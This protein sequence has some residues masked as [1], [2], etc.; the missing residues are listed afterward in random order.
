MD[1]LDHTIQKIEEMKSYP[2]LCAAG[3]EFQPD[4]T[5]DVP[6]QRVRSWCEFLDIID[7]ES[8]VLILN[9]TI[10]NALFP[11]IERSRKIGRHAWK[12][13]NYDPWIGSLKSLPAQII[14]P[15]QLNDRIP[16]EARDEGKVQLYW[17]IK[18][19]VIYAQFQPYITPIPSFEFTDLVLRR[20]RLA[21][22]GDPDD[23]V[24]VL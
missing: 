23:G 10:K 13:K 24:L 16:P 21:C 14:P 18:M 1:T 17:L 5:W 3:R 8:R 22:G 9:A 19:V 20:G 7:Q 11:E 4:E 12:T 15:D 2:W 6:V